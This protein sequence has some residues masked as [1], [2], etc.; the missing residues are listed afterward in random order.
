MPPPSSPPPLA[1]KGILLGDS[2]VGKTSLLTRYT[3]GSFSS[4]IATVGV[5]ARVKALAARG[6]PVK[7]RL[8]D[9]AGQERFRTISASFFRGAHV[10]AFV[11]DVTERRTFDA[12]RAW[13]AEA[14]AH[15]G[16]AGVACVLLA[17]KSDCAG[18]AVAREEGA[19]MA[20][21]YGMACVR[22]TTR[23][24]AR[25]RNRAPHARPPP[26][27]L[28]DE[29]QGRHQRRGRL[30][31][32]RGGGR[33]PRRRRAAG[34]LGRRPRRGAGAGARRVLR[35]RL[36]A[37]RRSAERSRGPPLSPPRSLDRRV[38]ARRHE[39]GKLCTAVRR[40]RHQPP[41]R[42]ELRRSP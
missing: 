19:A 17:N 3:E 4:A 8:W 31:R 36:S 5:D 35:G 27:L 14:R 11:Y 13:V 1:L 39:R 12:V 34:R 42:H 16:G 10:A 33:R 2:F 15:A 25:A 38:L 9:T 41:A 7:V 28:R 21:E 40:R 37:A 24:S 29:R 23:A 22:G 20:R 6:R 30:H 32:R 26:Q 18:G